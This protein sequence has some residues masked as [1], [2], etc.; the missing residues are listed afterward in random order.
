MTLLRIITARIFLRDLGK[1]R[2]LRHRPRPRAQEASMIRLLAVL[3]RLKVARWRL[4]RR[5]ARR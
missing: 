2:R 1:A 3:V 5:I 4:A